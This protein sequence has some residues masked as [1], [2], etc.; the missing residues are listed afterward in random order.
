MLSLHCPLTS[1]FW[2]QS[3][4][5]TEVE[6]VG[7]AAAE[8]GQ[9]Y[10]QSLHDLWVSLVEL[11]HLAVFANDNLVHLLQSAVAIETSVVHLLL[12]QVNQNTQSAGAVQNC[13]LLM[14][15]IVDFP[16]LASVMHLLPRQIN[17]DLQ[18]FVAVQKFPLGTVQIHVAK[19]KFVPTKTT[20]KHILII[21]FMNWLRGIKGLKGAKDWKDWK[22]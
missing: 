5:I 2:S 17:H 22:G 20:N 6:S 18:S 8:L 4:P 1:W 15:H 19:E 12:R 9:Q 16:A 13:P 3:I 14:V 7:S 21:F 11:H 10:I